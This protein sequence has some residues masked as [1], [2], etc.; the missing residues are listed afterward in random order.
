MSKKFSLATLAVAATLVVACGEEK[1]EEAAAEQAP[2]TTEQAAAE[3]AAAEPAATQEAAATPAA[4]GGE[5]VVAV[6]GPMTGD[7]AAFGEQLKR[8][9]E[10]AI[11]DINAKGG[12]NGK[13]LKLEI[14]DD[15]CDPKQAVQVANDLVKKGVAFVA[16]HFCSGSSIPASDIYAE[17]G[18]VQIT[19][20]STNPDFTEV[21]ASKGVKTIFRTCGRDDAQGV[22]AGPWLAKTYAGKKVAIL[23]DKSAYGQGLAN[24][25]AKNFEASG[26]TITIRDTYTAKEKDFSALISKL[27]DAAIDVV[28]IGGYHNDVGLITRQSREQGFNADIVSADALNTAEFWSIS[29][30]AG[31]GVRYSDGAS[32]V[33]LDSAK[34]VVAAFRAENYEPEGYTLNSYAAIQAWAEA[35]NKAGSVEGAKVADA[36]RA[37]PIPTVLGEL[38]FNEKGDL[39]KVNYAWYVWGADGKAVQEPLN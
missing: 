2:A 3:P 36:L 20:A 8:G 38:S 19:P 17:E 21:P 12:V 33:N 1:K 16:G 26:G 27:K 24:E 11:A 10:K 5:I 32:A 4:T 37:A 13:Q 30:P 28:Y 35:A 14:G 29:G 7:L 6:A 15:Q 34:D 25:T 22:F 9:A 18:I 23:D 31:E 39:T